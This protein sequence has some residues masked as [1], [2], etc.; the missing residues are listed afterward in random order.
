MSGIKKTSVIIND[1]ITSLINFMNNLQMYVDICRNRIKEDYKKY[2]SKLPKDMSESL[3]D[4]Y[5]RSDMLYNKFNKL[6]NKFSVA[7]A[8][9][10]TDIL[11]VGTEINGLR[12]KYELM[13]AEFNNFMTSQYKDANYTRNVKKKLKEFERVVR[14]HNKLVVTYNNQ[15]ERLITFDKHLKMNVI[16]YMS[17][18]KRKF[19]IPVKDYVEEF[20]SLVDDDTY[21]A[22]GQV[23]SRYLMDMVGKL[24]NASPGFPLIPIAK[25]EKID[26]HDKLKAEELKVERDY[27]LEDLKGKDVGAG[28]NESPKDFKGKEMGKGWNEIPKDLKGKEWNEMAKDFKGKEVGKG[29]N[30]IPKDFKSK[31]WN[32]RSKD[33]KGKDMGKGLNESP[34]DFKGKEMGKVWIQSPKDFKVE[35]MSREWNKRPKDFMG[36]DV[37]K[38]WNEDRKDKNSKSNKN[39]ETD[40]RTEMASIKTKPKETTD[41]QMETDELQDQK[42]KPKN[43]EID[44]QTETALITTEPKEKTDFKMEIAKLLDY[45]PKTKDYKNSNYYDISNSRPSLRVLS[46]KEIND[47]LEAEYGS[48]Q[49]AIDNKPFEKTENNYKAENK[50][51]KEINEQNINMPKNEHPVDYQSLPSVDSSNEHNFDENKYYYELDFDVSDDMPGTIGPGGSFE[52]DNQ[53]LGSSDQNFKS[54]EEELR[55]ADE[56]FYHRAEETKPSSMQNLLES[57]NSSLVTSPIDKRHPADDQSSL[58]VDSRND[59]HLEGDSV[60]QTE[61]LEDSKSAPSVDETEKISREPT[62]EI[63]REILK[64]I[65]NRKNFEKTENVI[66]NKFEEGFGV[67]ETDDMPEAISPA[68]AGSLSKKSVQLRKE[69]LKEELKPRIKKQRTD[70][71]DYEE[72]SFENDN[73]SL[74]TSDFVIE[75]SVLVPNNPEQ[76]EEVEGTEMSDQENEDENVEMTEDSRVIR[77]INSRPKFPSNKIRQSKTIGVKKYIDLLKT[78]KRNPKLKSK[79]ISSISKEKKPEYADE[80]KTQYV[81]GNSETSQLTT[82]DISDDSQQVTEKLPMQTEEAPSEISDA[83]Y[84]WSS[85]FEDSQ[86]VPEDLSVQKKETPSEISDATY[87]SSIYGNSQQIPEDS[88]VKRKE[89][90]SEISD[91]TYSSSIYGNSQQIPEDSSVK[92]KETPSEISDATYSSSIYGNSQQIPEDLSVKRKETPSEISDATCNLSS[93]SGDNQQITEKL[94]AQTEEAASKISDA[95]YSLSSISG[96]SQ[97]VLEDLS[98]QRKEAPSEISDATHSS[99]IFGDSKSVIEDFIGRTGE[100]PASSV[101]TDDSNIDSVQQLVTDQV[102]EKPPGSESSE[103]KIL[104]DDSSSLLNKSSTPK[105]KLPRKRPS[106]PISMIRKELHSKKSKTLQRNQ[107]PASENQTADRR[108]ISK[109][110]VNTEEVDTIEPNESKQEKRKRLLVESEKSSESTEE[111]ESKLKKKPDQDNDSTMT[112]VSES[113]SPSDQDDY[114]KS[115]DLEMRPAVKDSLNEIKRRCKFI[116]RAAKKAP[117]VDSDPKFKSRYRKVLSNSKNVKPEV[118]DNE[119]VTKSDEIKRDY[120][121]KLT[122]PKRYITR[123]YTL[124]K[125]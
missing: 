112:E 73:Q 19:V 86:Q 119:E 50:D 76:E 84:G 58:S 3:H 108:R 110:S 30:E 44:R 74:G 39:E 80:M 89:T 55:Y 70:R 25:L 66:T 111:I 93:I 17:N 42:A 52:D 99:S 82:S 106:E 65:E 15:I 12:Q 35:E 104:S 100:N 78:S 87:S 57:K 41:F 88:S 63:T 107:K 71:H 72:E 27:D 49:E 4:Q 102:P 90:P 59:K 13:V 60:V 95:T 46:E 125:K 124:N 18:H 10:Y 6:L 85:I 48:K 43:V 7:I 53:S 77:Q 109:R 37:D 97:Q 116:T 47:I 20:E 120:I 9:D 75:P 38:G 51:S 92:R 28:W 36:R 69:K 121:S 1:S 5:E 54:L 122:H 96:D 91:A 117:S 56:Y 83:A 98:V 45:A 113:S 79:I 31:E 40:H 103:S 14:K 68:G 115:H 33:F 94:P 118:K 29:L 8:Q 22:R 16:I 123:S 64:E 21:K 26:F 24:N 32:E 2:L 23:I 114:I 62:R 101:A 34:K 67:E 61:F 105:Q 11:T 81:V